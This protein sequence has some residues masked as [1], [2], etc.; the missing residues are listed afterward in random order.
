MEPLLMLAVM[1]L[2][3]VAVHTIVTSTV[4]VAPDGHLIVPGHGGRR[5]D[6]VVPRDGELDVTGGLAGFC[7]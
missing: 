3:A 6:T 4:L 7:A 5:F 1:P 2:L